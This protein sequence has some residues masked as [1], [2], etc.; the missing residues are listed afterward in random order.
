MEYSVDDDRTPHEQAE[1][2]G[3]LPKTLNLVNVKWHPKKTPKAP[4]VIVTKTC[5]TF[6]EKAHKQLGT[7][8]IITATARIEDTAVYVLIIR[9]VK[10]KNPQAHKLKCSSKTPMPL[11]K[12]ALPRMI[13]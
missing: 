7:D 13:F 1:D 5:I 3:I 4:D 2:L 12:H 10:E 8:H 11:R 9:P 6:A